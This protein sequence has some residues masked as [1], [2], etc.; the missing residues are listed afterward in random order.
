ML[1]HRHYDH[2]DV[3]TL[4]RLHAVHDPLMAMPLGNDA[5]VRAAVPAARCVTVDWWD[6]L[7]LGS[8][9]ATTLTPAYHWSN[10]W[11]TDTRMML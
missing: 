1:S 10:R 7:P 2:I 5:I 3:D 8:E 4:R 9:I 6:R 11:P